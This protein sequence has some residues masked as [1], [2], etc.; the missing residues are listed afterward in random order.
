M[1]WNHAKSMADRNRIEQ[2]FGV[3]FT[4]LL[5]LPYFNT[6]KVSVI[7]PMHVLL[8]TSKLTVKKMVYYLMY[9]FRTV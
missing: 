9:N 8:G 5:Q 4:E 3:W 7:D 1:A 2:E 6:M